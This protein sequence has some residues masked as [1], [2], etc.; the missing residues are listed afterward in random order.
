LRLLAYSP[1]RQ[2]ARSLFFLQIGLNM[3]WSWMFF[4]AH[5]PVLGVINVFLQFLAVVATA[6][7]FH[8]LDRIAGWC[9]VPLAAWVA[10]AAV[11]NVEIWRLMADTGRLSSGRCQCSEQPGKLVAERL[12]SVSQKKPNGQR[13][14]YGSPPCS[15]MWRWPK[16]GTLGKGVATKLSNPISTSKAASV[17]GLSRKTLTAR[18]S[19]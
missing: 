18:F 11:L 13:S 14:R 6:A 17:G 5:N 12:R 15:Q 1:S 2:L 19:S 16:R 7:V 3:A 4:A 10:F 8:R 9:L